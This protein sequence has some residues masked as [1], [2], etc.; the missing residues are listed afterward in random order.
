M[1]SV[2]LILAGAA[3]V[4]LFLFEWAAYGPHGT[5]ASPPAAYFGVDYRTYSEA[6]RSLLTGHGFYPPVELAGPWEMWTSAIVY[7]PTSIPFFAVAGSLSLALWLAIPTTVTAWAVLWHRPSL[8]AW[9]LIAVAVATPWA[10]WEWWC[11]NPVLWAVALI[12]LAT[13]RGWVGPLVLVKPTLFVA[14]FALIGI[15]TRGWWLTMGACCVMALVTL[16]LWPDYLTVLRNMRGSAGLLHAWGDLSLLL[17]PIIA[18]FGT[19]RGSRGAPISVR[20]AQAV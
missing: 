5:F 13:H 15:R 6:A 20:S 10:I 18:W 12:A 11:G 4:G 17:V 3:V 2:G 7:P 19:T 14:P 9:S 16:P 8:F 1:R